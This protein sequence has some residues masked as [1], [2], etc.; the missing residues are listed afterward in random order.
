VATALVD[1]PA[2]LEWCRYWHRPTDLGSDT[3]DRIVGA[4][5]LLTPIFIAVITVWVYWKALR[6][7]RKERR[8]KQN[9]RAET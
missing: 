3:L 9:T 6:M 2:P 5:L 7:L 1:T 8:S 4:S